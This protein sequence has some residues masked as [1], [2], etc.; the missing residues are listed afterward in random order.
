VEQSQLHAQDVPVFNI[1]TMTPLV[2]E[3]TSAFYSHQ[4]TVFLNTVTK[5][6]LD[7]PDDDFSMDPH[8][9]RMDCNVMSWL[10]GTGS[11]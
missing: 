3:Q 2:L 8:W 10:F 5:Y 11:L 9:H 1:K 4:C 7:C 6:A